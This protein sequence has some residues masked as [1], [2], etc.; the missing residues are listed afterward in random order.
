[1]K[2]KKLITIIVVALTVIILIF[3]IGTQFFDVKRMKIPKVG[4]EILNPL[5]EYLKSSHQSPEE[6]IISSFENKDIIFL[7]EF[8]SIKQNIEFVSRLVPYLHKNG[9]YNIGFEY[10]LKQDQNKLDTLVIRSET[11]N[12]PKAREFLFNSLMLSGYKE[13]IDILKTV[14]EFNQTLDENQRP[15]RIVGLDVFK[16]WY[17]IQSENDGNN[18]EIIKQV[19][20]LGIP[21]EFIAKTI[22]EVFIDKNEKALIFCQVQHSF[23]KYIDINYQEY[24]NV[25]NIEKT[26]R[27]GNIVYEMIGSRAGTIIMHAPWP[28][29]KAVNYLNFPAEGVIDAL[30]ET[31]SL[32]NKHAG[33]DTVG[34]P[35][36]DLPILSSIFIKGHENLTLDQFCDGY[37]IQGPLSEY[38]ASS[39]FPDF[40]NK[41]NLEKAR[42][43]MPLAKGPDT[44]AENFNKI[45]EQN[46]TTL[47]NFLKL[48]KKE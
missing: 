5:Q 14:W 9:I 22:K 28:D 47:N 15:V 26:G 46:T 4:E 38:E 29:D 12:E 43:M 7:G 33:F 32:D 24:L 48:F 39:S 27:A 25:L 16:Q 42:E 8:F 21:D 11:F 35:F 20:S 18:P 36:G 40:I 6:Y 34:T 3:I 37:I 1:M 19:Y 30:M 10:A 41:D 2:N 17:Y 23:T 13:Y 31:L 45:I 44:S